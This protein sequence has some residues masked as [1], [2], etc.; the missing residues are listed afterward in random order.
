MK[1]TKNKNSLICIAPILTAITQLTNEVMKME[2]EEVEV[3]SKGLH[4]SFLY[5]ETRKLPPP[6][7]NPLKIPELMLFLMI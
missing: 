1:T 2:N 5:I 3:A 4:P 7:P 6:R